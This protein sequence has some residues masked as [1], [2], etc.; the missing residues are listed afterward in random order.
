LRRASLPRIYVAQGS[1]SKPF[2]NSLLGRELINAPSDGLLESAVEQRAAFTRR[3]R[4]FRKVPQAEVRALSI[5]EAGAL[6]S[7]SLNSDAAL[8]AL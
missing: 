7:S 1:C 8:S 6:T 2:F 4:H 5:R 3:G